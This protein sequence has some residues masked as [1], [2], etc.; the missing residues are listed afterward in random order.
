[1]DHQKQKIE[2]VVVMDVCLRL[3]KLNHVTI[4]GKYV[5]GIWV[6]GD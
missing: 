4:I 3:S 5:G 1:M 6:L 2:D